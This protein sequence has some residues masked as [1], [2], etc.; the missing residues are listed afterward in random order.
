MPIL[1][2]RNIQRISRG[3]GWAA[4]ALILFTVLTGYGITAFRTVTGL[5]FGILGKATS[6]RFHHYTDIPL[7]IF[8]SIHVA[9]ALWMRLS[10]RH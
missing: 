1:T 10:K 3:C 6:Q 4:A 8:L 7:I 5:T 9:T 2:K